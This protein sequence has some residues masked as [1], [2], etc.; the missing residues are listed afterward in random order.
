[1]HDHDK[2]FAFKKSDAEKELQTRTLEKE[3]YDVHALGK[4]QLDERRKVMDERL[5]DTMIKNLLDEL[6]SQNE[7]EINE[8]KE[9]QDKLVADKIKEMETEREEL[10]Q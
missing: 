2:S 4:A 10:E 8:F 6:D 1:M 9:K 5:K 7:N 3:N